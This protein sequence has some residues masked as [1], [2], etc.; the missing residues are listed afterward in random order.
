[1]KHFSKILFLLTLLTGYSQHSFAVAVNIPNVTIEETFINP[2]AGNQYGFGSYDVTNNN[3]D[4]TKSIHAFAVENPF[5]NT[6]SNGR[7]PDFWQSVIG[8][9]V[10]NQGLFGIDLSS[11][12]SDLYVAYFTNEF[13][14]KSGCQPGFPINPFAAIFPFETQGNFSFE[15]S[16][17]NSKFV[18]F[19]I[20]N[21]ILATGETILKPVPIPATIW[22]FGTALFS[23][24]VSMK[25]T[26]I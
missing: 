10:N 9:R 17:A 20:D 8:Q 11:F 18:A 22:L 16:Q 25:K 21:N 26:T 14:C 3:P 12:T 23:L 24:C 6:L 15:A 7:A 2:V 5:L 1:M 4:I 13:I 19:D